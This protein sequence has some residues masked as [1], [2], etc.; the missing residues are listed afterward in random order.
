MF[1]ND[2]VYYQKDGKVKALGYT[3][4]NA[5]LEKGLPVFGQSGGGKA[6]GNLVVPA[7]LLLLQQTFRGDNDDKNDDGNNGTA[8]PINNVEDRN[9]VEVIGEGL[10]DKL[11]QLMNTKQNKQAR[12][13]QR[14]KRKRKKHT[15]KRPR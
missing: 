1:N 13:T 2:L 9:N 5:L 6:L 4:E 8:S 10:F 12:H 7:G 11:L 14:R 15:R 3:I